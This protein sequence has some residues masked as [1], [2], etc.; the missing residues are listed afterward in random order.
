MR[1]SQAGIVPKLFVATPTYGWTQFIVKIKKDTMQIEPRTWLKPGAT[2][3]KE[4]RSR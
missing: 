1:R 4:P 3:L 2:Q